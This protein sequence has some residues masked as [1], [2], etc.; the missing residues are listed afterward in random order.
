MKRGAVRTSWK[1]LPLPTQREALSFQ[2]FYSDADAEQISKGLIPE[3]MEDKW[4]IFHELGWVYFHR[5][6]TGSCIYWLKLDGS[7]AGVRVTES[8]VNRDREQYNVTDTVF[9][10][11]FLRC[12]IDRLLLDKPTQF[13]KF[14][15]PPIY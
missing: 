6:W 8:W 7:P 14:P 2:A 4:F 1:T 11:E 9:D 12:L 15:Q 13:P 3:E 5:S 10:R